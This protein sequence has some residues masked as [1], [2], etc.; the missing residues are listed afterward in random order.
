LITCHLLFVRIIN[1]LGELASAAHGVAC[2]I[3]ALAYMPGSA[4]QIA[5]A[6]L[7]GQYLGARDYRRA[8]RSVGVTSLAAGGLMV[9]AGLVFFFAATPLVKFFLGTQT[10]EI[11]P[12]AT[13]LLRIVAAA[14]PALG[15][16][17]VLTG[18]LR[19]AGDTRWPLVITFI[20]FLGIRLPLAYF[21]AHETIDVPFVA[22][23]LHGLGLGVVGAW[24]AMV[25]DVFLRFLL[26]VYRFLQG[27]WTRIE[28]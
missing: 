24:Y 15:I 27:G 6:T 4:F 22:H 2:Q 7:A 13:R 14:I 12:L 21:F 9:A 28:V 16:A 26:L 20:G 3:E 25:I 23:P 8:M 18:A 5:A 17:M 11:V 19:G 1:Q 10:T